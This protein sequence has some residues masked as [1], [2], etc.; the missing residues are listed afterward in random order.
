LCIVGGEKRRELVSG[1]REQAKIV[2]LG[3]LRVSGEGA[4]ILHNQ[5]EFT[6][7]AQ[8]PRR[9]VSRIDPA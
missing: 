6:D 2:S 8:V 3:L 5:C 9:G 7:R 1:A 4:L